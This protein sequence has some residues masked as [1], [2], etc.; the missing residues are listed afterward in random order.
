MAKP[1][2][3]PIQGL[4]NPPDPE[5][6]VPG[7]FILNPDGS[8]H[9]DYGGKLRIY[10]PRGELC[11]PISSSLSDTTEISSSIPANEPPGR[12]PCCLPDGTCID[13][14][15]PDECGG[16]GGTF[17]GTDL[18]CDDI[19]C[20]S[21]P[22]P[23]SS[24]DAPVDTEALAV[25]TFGVQYRV[26]TSVYAGPDE[27]S[28]NGY[29]RLDRGYITSDASGTSLPP[30]VYMTLSPLWA[31]NEAVLYRGGYSQWVNLDN[32]RVYWIDRDGVS[33]SV[34]VGPA[35]GIV[36]YYWDAGSKTLS[37]YGTIKFMMCPQVSCGSNYYGIDTFN[38]CC[39]CSCTGDYVNDCDRIYWY[40]EC[41]GTDECDTQ[42][43]VQRRANHSSYCG[44]ASVRFSI[45]V[46][47]WTAT[48]VLNFSKSP[49]LSTWLWNHPHTISIN[50]N[51]GTRKVITT[52][53]NPDQC[54]RYIQ[55]ADLI[56][57][58]WQRQSSGTGVPSM[59]FYR[60]FAMGTRTKRPQQINPGCCAYQLQDDIYENLYSSYVWTI[61]ISGLGG[62]L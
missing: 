28:C 52:Y 36:Y 17:M 4:I 44:G 13:G 42:N 23:E 55:T 61:R 8:P 51:V 10:D 34:F 5:P 43:N 7:A 19:V 27:G 45:T 37:G 25:G 58:A 9:I 53:T 1:F 2:I 3:D 48:D 16:M 11:C 30:T 35:N 29:T 32:K 21:P 14:A 46:S 39:P 38:S 47:D 33:R 49:L 57:G 50:A 22:D 59:S 12:G 31:I 62:L 15:M 24:S 40:A 26:Q 18:T 54:S 56:G 41:G 6:L 20:E 60:N